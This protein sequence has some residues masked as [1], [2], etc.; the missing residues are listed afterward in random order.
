MVAEA[1]TQSAQRRDGLVE[2]TAAAAPR[3]LGQSL[4]KC[5]IPNHLPTNL[6]ENPSS[7]QTRAGR[8]RQRTNLAVADHLGI[9][10]VSTVRYREPSR[11]RGAP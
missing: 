1:R 11:M 9:V 6:R 10:E 5:R 4:R 8:G 7:A 2:T 3:L